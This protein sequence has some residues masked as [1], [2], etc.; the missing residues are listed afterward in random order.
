VGQVIALDE[1]DSVLA[2]EEKPKIRRSQ[3]C[4][5][6]RGVPT[7]TVPSISTA[8]LTMRWTQSSASLRST[9]LY[10]RITR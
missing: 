10:S 1:A 4:E 5:R 9:S 2:L 8:R 6:I 3:C 7:V